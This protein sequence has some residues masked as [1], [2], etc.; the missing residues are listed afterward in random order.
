M[1]SFLGFAARCVASGM[2][3]WAVCGCGRCW[4]RVVRTGFWAGYAGMLGTAEPDGLPLA[5][6][7]ARRTSAERRRGGSDYGMS[8]GRD[9]KETPPPN[10]RLVRQTHSVRAGVRCRV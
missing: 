4:H 3:A 5:G 1:Y 9:A 8:P 7:R 6:S 2:T 10:K